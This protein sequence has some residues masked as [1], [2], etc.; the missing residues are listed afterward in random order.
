MTTEDLIR[1]RR[2]LHAHPET[3]FEEVETAKMVADLLTSF[4]IEVTTGI[5]GTGVVGI[6]KRGDGPNVGLRADMDAPD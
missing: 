2:H 3:A 6:L 1:W 4:G 5:G